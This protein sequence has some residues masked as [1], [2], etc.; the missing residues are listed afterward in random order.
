M[1]SPI[2][3]RTFSA[4][5]II[6][7]ITYAGHRVVPVN[8][9]TIGFVYLIA[10][11]LIALRWGLTASVASSL[12]AV[13]SLNYFYVPPIGSFT[14]QDPENWVALLA[15]LTTSFIVTQLSVRAR[16]DAV[17]AISSRSEMER[18]YSFS[19][20]ILLTDASREPVPEQIARQLVQVF[21]CPGAA[22][23]DAASVE[24]YTAGPENLDSE[25]ARMRQTAVHGS[26]ER[27]TAKDLVIFPVN[28]GGRPIGSA[29]VKKLELSEPALDSL[30]NLIAI[31]LERARTVQSANRA[32]AARQSEE[33]K[34][35]LLDA[36]AHEFKTPLTSIKAA[37]SGLLD[38]VRKLPSTAP[39]REL[40]SVVEEETDR[41]TAL[42]SETIRMARIEAGKV[43]LERVPVDPRDV[44]QTA[45]AQLGSRAA[46][47]TI[48]IDSGSAPATVSLDPEL[49]AIAVRQ[50]IDNALKYSPAG[51]PI[52]I[53]LRQANDEFVVEVRDH[54]PG[55]APGEQGRIFEKFYRS[56][57]NGK[58][59][60]G[61]GMGLSIAREIVELHG[62]HAWIESQGDGVSFFTS[63][64][65]PH[66]E[67]PVR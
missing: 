57:G 10:V 12:A 60:A 66:Q 46:D 36:I 32:E 43:R 50:A 44:I 64:P 38:L 7:A 24:L 5:V 62:G 25:A 2:L 39:E 8:A 61:S 9:T 54:G 1:E 27:D 53:F 34:S 22:V 65:T 18:L 13:L 26:I 48:S 35:T 33:L 30:A 17:N 40:A 15:F 21:D 37:A 19:R 11:L 42:V 47:R 49:F 52:D 4:V 20:S 3:L 31:G 41:L 55:I 45:V 29:A 28:L 51:R 14:V 58:H 16:L 59:I 56:P 6:E 67:E 23:F 63:M